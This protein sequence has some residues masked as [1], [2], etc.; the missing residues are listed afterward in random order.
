VLGLG[1]RLADFRNRERPERGAL[2][3]GH[4]T[5]PRRRLA[6]H[7]FE[8]DLELSA[9]RLM[10]HSSRLSVDTRSVI[11]LRRLTDKS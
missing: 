10:L 7:N 11:Y 6:R 5:S 4:Q 9:K 2:S 8:P 3:G 1:V